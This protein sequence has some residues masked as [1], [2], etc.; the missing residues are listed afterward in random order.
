MVRFSRSTCIEEEDNLISK[1]QKKKMLGLDYDLRIRNGIKTNWTWI[2]LNLCYGY[3]L[4][5]QLQH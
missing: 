2:R 3:L 5:V 1:Q 4:Y